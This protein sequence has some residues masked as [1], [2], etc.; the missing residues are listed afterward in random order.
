MV[1][2]ILANC[3]CKPFFLNWAARSSRV[4][5]SASLPFCTGPNLSCM[6]N[7]LNQW[8]DEARK[9]DR[10]MNLAT[11]KVDT[12]FN[13]CHHQEEEL[14]L[15]SATMPSFNILPSSYVYCTIVR[16]IRDIICVVICTKIHH[17]FNCFHPARTTTSGQFLRIIT[18]TSLAARCF[19]DNHPALQLERAKLRMVREVTRTMHRCVEVRKP[20]NRRKRLSNVSHSLI[21][22]LG[23][24]LRSVSQVR[25][26]VFTY[27]RDNIAV[28]KVFARDPYY[29]LIQRDKKMTTISFVGNT[30]C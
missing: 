25:D 8:G 1:E 4:R 30:G 28:V 2:E 11:G 29:T 9:M 10:V 19:N 7:K 26:A 16:K 27:A 13:S 15:T 5:D 14:Q 12:C 18:R 24:H 23:G 20:Q 21:W 6:K 3:S 17:Q 22:V